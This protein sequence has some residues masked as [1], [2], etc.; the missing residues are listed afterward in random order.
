MAL[1]RRLTE[2]GPIDCIWFISSGIASLLGITE[3]GA[4]VE[5]AMA[6]HES[7]IGFPGSVRKNETA[8]CS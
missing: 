8:Y 6:S 5:V 2:R 1:S 3:D 4:S 7:V